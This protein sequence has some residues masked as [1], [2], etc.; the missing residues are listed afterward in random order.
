M[1][2]ILFYSSL[3]L[4]GLFF[5]CS[6]HSNEK[7][8]EAQLL[9]DSIVKS[10]KTALVRSEQENDFLRLNGKV[11]PDE[12]KQAKVFA[13]VSGKIESVNVELGDYVK[14]GQLLAV[15]N[16]TEV[17]EVSNNLSLAESNVIIARKNLEAT[18]DLY[19]G[20]LATEQEYLN[21][22]I[23]YKK[24]MSE[25]NRA[26]QVA[27]ITG[28][29]SSSYQVKA[30]ISG[31]IIDKNITSNSEVRQDNNA[32]LFAIADLSNVWIIANVYETDMKRVH[33]DDVVTVKTLA[34]PDKTYTGKIDKI[35]N[36]LDPETRTMRIR[37]TLNN[38]GQ[39]LKPEMFATVRV[40]IK[41]ENKNLAVPSRALVMD[42]SNY[43]VVIK[44][45]DKLEIKKVN[46]LKRVG[47]KTFISG[48]SE[49]DEV[50][51][52]SQVFL[53]QALSVN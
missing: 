29:S 35:Y 17:A 45:K 36:V 7:V 43:F 37:V 49:N 52:E 4:C 20:R 27:S 22:D 6:K 46:L 5:S 14:K 32:D 25:L 39:E 2:H 24:A 3:L 50:V 31:Y 38:P 30:P 12:T 40:N 10:V 41:S 34:D 15:L 42:N 19:E 21:A 23:S 13:L 16:S 53:Y 1:K 18:K 48:L 28:G 8:K 51:I 9:P 47:D 44:S 11:E 26:S 33:L